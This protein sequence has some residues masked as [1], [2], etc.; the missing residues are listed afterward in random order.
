MLGKITEKLANVMMKFSIALEHMLR[1]FL[2]DEMDI[3]VTSK[4][5]AI[6]KYRFQNIMGK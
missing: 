1:L 3:D 4:E 2:P 5:Y 6:E